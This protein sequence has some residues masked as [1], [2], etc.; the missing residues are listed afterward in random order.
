LLDD[1]FRSG[2]ARVSDEPDTGPG[3]TGAGGSSSEGGTPSVSPD[4]LDGDCDAGCSGP[5]APGCGALAHRYTFDGSGSELLDAAGNA[6]GALI[7][8]VLSGDGYV[9]LTPDAAQYVDL[10]NYLIS[11]RSSVTLELWLEW[12]GGAPWQRLF[13]FGSS[14]LGEGERGR[15]LTYLFLTPSVDEDSDYDGVMRLTYG[16]A[17]GEVEL[18]AALALPSERLVHVAAVI[19]APSE[20]MLLYQD[21]ELVGS[22]ELARPLSRLDDVNAWLGRSQFTRD[23]YLSARLLEFRIYG[24]PLDAAAIRASFQAGSDPEFLED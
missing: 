11:R 15:G 23:P 2:A 19:D 8:A 10:P 4:C 16:N 21:G 17:D 6:H 13:E 22:R 9:E 1:E 20:R 7:G 5:S 14:S 24:A 3:S 12:Y 18:N